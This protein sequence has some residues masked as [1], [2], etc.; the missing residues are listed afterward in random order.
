V[1][2]LALDREEALLN[3]RPAWIPGRIDIGHEGADSLTSI[4]WPALA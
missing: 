1:S 4:P 3:P 2:V